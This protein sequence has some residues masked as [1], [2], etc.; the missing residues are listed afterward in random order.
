MVLDQCI[1]LYFQLYLIYY[2]SLY[3]RRQ[4]AES[5]KIMC[6]ASFYF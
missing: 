4:V 1:L 5:L 3:E 2:K 6:V